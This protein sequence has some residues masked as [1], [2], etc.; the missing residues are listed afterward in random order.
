[1]NAG[2]IPEVCAVWKIHKKLFLCV[3][4]CVK[5]TGVQNELELTVT[6]KP[7]QCE[8]VFSWIQVILLFPARGDYLLNG[9]DI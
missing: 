9:A 8:E 7:I 1:M 3:W 2:C 4:P 6:V 5:H